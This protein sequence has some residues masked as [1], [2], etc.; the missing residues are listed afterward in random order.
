MLE[1][2]AADELIHRASRLSADQ[3]A[4]LAASTRRT[5]GRGLRAYLGIRSRALKMAR[6]AAEAALKRADMEAEMRAKVTLL[7]EAV[8]SASV[9]AAKRQGRDT[10]GVRE[11]WKRFE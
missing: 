11:A 1:S 3:V 7:N 4:D 2:S 8:L 9:A 10:S 5:I 6:S